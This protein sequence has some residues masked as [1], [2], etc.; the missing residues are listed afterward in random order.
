MLFFISLTHDFRCS[1]GNGR[2]SPAGTMDR[3]SGSGLDSCLNPNAHSTSH[4]MIPSNM[5]QGNR[6]PDAAHFHSSD[7]SV[8]SN[9]I[10]SQ[11][12]VFPNG[13]AKPVTGAKPHSYISFG[14]DDILMNKPVQ[15]QSRDSE[16]LT[17]SSQSASMQSPSSSAPVTSPN[18]SLNNSSSSSGSSNSGTGDQ[19]I[20]CK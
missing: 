2:Q 10:S 20:G 15:Q 19:F 1:S 5:S 4:S 9:T 3:V 7:D 12:M 18:L 13:I 6:V 14:I 17:S 11:T 16:E 8:T